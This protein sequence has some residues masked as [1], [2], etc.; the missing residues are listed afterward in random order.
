MIGVHAGDDLAALRLAIPAMQH[1]QHL[2]DGIIRLRARVGVVDLACVE[3]RQLDQLLGQGDGGVGDATEEGVVAGELP[4]LGAESVDD[5]LMVEPGHVVPEARVG[6]DVALAVHI[7][8]PDA[9]PMRQDHR[10]FGIQRTQVSEAV[11]NGLHVSLFPRIA[12]IGVHSGSPFVVFTVTRKT[13]LGK[14]VSA[15]IRCI[16]KT[17]CRARVLLEVWSAPAPRKG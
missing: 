11:E 12:H 3:R 13:I 9:V 1:P 6:I 2:D 7:E 17:R 4:R 16:G 8:D 15:A 14:E 5:A 10:T